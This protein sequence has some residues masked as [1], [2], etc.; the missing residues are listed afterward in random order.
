MT[1]LSIL[2]GVSAN[3]LAEENLEK[4]WHRI[5]QINLT[6]AFNC[7]SAAGEQMIEQKGGAIINIASM[8]ASIVPEKTRPGWLGEYVLLAY[9]ASKGGVKQLTRAIAGLWAGYGIRANSISPGYV[10]TPLTAGPHSDLQL[11]AALESKIPLGYIASPA[12]IAGAVLFL[13][14]ED[15]RYITGQDLVMDGGFVCR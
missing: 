4:L 1:F 14:S 3:A 13:A 8:S 2:L 6:G 12:D 5:I 9:C 7:C 10:D 11:R 15:A